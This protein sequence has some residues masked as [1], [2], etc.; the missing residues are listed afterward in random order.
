MLLSAGRV[1]IVGAGIG[2]L[3]T[4][5]RLGAAGRSVL[6]LDRA[7]APGGKMRT[8]PTPVGPVD[9]GPTV[10]TMKPVFE[11]LFRAAGTT[12]D[13]ELTLHP[14]SI[15]ARH[16]WRDGSTLDLTPDRSENAVAM[17]AFG[18][19]RARTDYLHFA[20]EAQRL[21]EAFDAPMMQ[22]AVPSQLALTSRV[23][24]EPS[25]IGAM[26]PLSTL[27]QK[28]GRRFA[29]P[30]LRQLY[31]RYATYVGGSPFASPAVLSLIS[32]SEALGVWAV[33]GG[34]HTL[35]QTLQRIAKQHGVE[36]RFGTE[37]QR[38]DVQNGRV[39]A[40]QSGDGRHPC[41]HVVFN[42]DPRALAHG[43]LGLGPQRAVDPKPLEERSL[44]AWVWTFAARP[45]GPA[46]AHHN[47]F[48]G[49]DPALEFGP[50]AAGQM[51][52]DPT[53]Y[54][55][56]QDR[57]TNIAARNGTPDGPERFEII[58]NGAP[59]DTTQPPSQREI[60]LCR[61]R[62]FGTLAQF[63]LT[64]D[65]APPDRALTTPWDFAQMFP[66]S[67]GSLYGQSPHGMM[68]AFKRPTAQTR[69]PGLV[70][71]GGGAHPGAGVPM[72][73]LSARHAAA[74]ILGDRTSTSLS[75]PTA[76]RGGMSTA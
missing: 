47:V 14:A 46:L 75:R 18:G 33:E 15:L 34:M 56:A 10:L 4:A 38:I 32:H 58:M 53:L 60:D 3:A 66:G 39:A 36:F 25:L 55:C 40:V 43:M 9:A 42:G 64:F 57:A 21:F 45:R 51:P 1:I 13:A 76:T 23:L 24:R 12:L 44:S 6:V 41:D 30:R 11:E 74:A 73:T 7:Q 22:A 65:H 31:G 29:D 28:L 70:L 72:A 68:A 37:A 50:I 67:A 69:L 62:V 16:W 61:K 2:G 19:P 8:M 52:E 59:T 26:S 27:W 71:V 17:E 54:I 48:F 20:T 49:Q 35:A 5:V 63:G